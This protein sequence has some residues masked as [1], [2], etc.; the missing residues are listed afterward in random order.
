MLGKV[1]I[2]I[3][4]CMV[5][6]VCPLS[7]ATKGKLEQIDRLLSTGEH[8]RALNEVHRLREALPSSERLTAWELDFR[9]EVWRVAHGRE[10]LYYLLHLSNSH[11]DAPGRRGALD[12]VTANRARSDWQFVVVCV[13]LETGKTRW[14]RAV[15][16]LVYLAVDPHSDVLY[17]YR[18]RVL[19]LAPDSGKV[20]EQHDLP[21]GA[22]EVHVLLIGSSLA[23]THLHSDRTRPYDR[24]LVYDVRA[25]VVKEVKAG[26]YC[27]LAPDESRR[28][29]PTDKGWD[30]VSV[31][32]GR[33]QWSLQAI[34]QPSVVPQWHGGHPAFILGTEWQRGAVT[35]MNLRTGEPRWSTALGWGAYT[36]NQHQLSGGGYQDIWTP[37]TA[38]GEY[39]L[40][41]DGS[42]RLYLLD[43]TD[44]RPAATPRLDRD[45]LAMP[46]QYG[47]QLIVP[48]F[49]W[50]R[51]FSI[52]NLIRPDASAGVS[53][54][55]RQTRCLLALGRQQEA[56]AVLDRLVERAPQ[57]SAAWSQ[58]AVACKALNNTEEEAFS[59]CQALSLSGRATDDDLRSRWGLLRL[60][61]LEGKPAWTLEEVEGHVYA[62]TLVG[63]LW[64]VRTDSLDIDR[65]ARMDHEIAKLAATTELQALLGYSSRPGRP[66]PRAP[67]KTDDRIPREWYTVGGDQRTSGP[68]SYLGRQFRSIKGGGVRI[69]SG[70]EMSD[71]PSQLEDVG[72]WKI[73]LAPSGPLGYGRGVFELDD[74]L[75]PVR[76]L[77][78]P[79]VG[80]DLPEW[81]EVMFVRSTIRTIG[82]VVG[83]SKGAAVQVYSRQGVLLNEAPVGRFVSSRV[84]PAAFVSMGDGYL[85]CDRQLVWVGPD[86]DRRVWRFGPS[87]ARTSTERWGDRWRYFGD[88]LR[89]NACLYVTGLDGRL[90]VFD[91]THVTG[92]AIL[93]PSSPFAI[94][95]GEAESAGSR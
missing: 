91:S 85:F 89:T 13:A 29:R 18:E 73:H 75:R 77:I 21:D 84:Q 57:S 45:F 40:A 90:Y 12:S 16:G 15:N 47:K 58:R 76:W 1:A 6:W 3:G 79:T 62:G 95:G 10:C 66:I 87:L 70:I 25:K 69:L 60:Y 4:I 59:Q 50:V 55:I 37:L 20:L 81:V 26:D 35:S 39:L 82:I 27:L 93:K 31:P 30:C 49:T 92:T 53:L 32:E 8:E 46:F 28:L 5:T 54:Q 63:D 22:G 43:P 80:G 41:L 9:G 34:F 61:D 36:A 86:D 78:R 65:A 38:I 17:L 42:R 71:L 83:S 67:A 52:A 48:S 7:A 14:S 2:G 88:P 56:M 74:D 68:V 11:R 19:L 24:L 72:E 44:G 51:S 94:P 64:R 23:M 33:L